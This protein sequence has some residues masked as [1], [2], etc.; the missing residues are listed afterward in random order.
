MRGR[1]IAIGIAAT[2]GVLAGAAPMA[3][4]PLHARV[5]GYDNVHVRVADP[6]K[7]VDW[8]VKHLGARSD[9]SN[10]RVHFGDTVVAIVATKSPQP[11]AGSV[12]DHFAVSFA[13]VD[14]RIRE[15]EAAGIAVKKSQSSGF[16]KSVFIEDPW[17]VRIELLQDP[18]ALGFHH[19]H[20]SVPDPQAVLAWYHERLGG[21]RGKLGGSDGLRYG[22][23]WL[24]AARAA[25]PTPSAERAIMN[26]AFRV[27]NLQQ[28]VSE[29]QTKG[30]QVVS[31][32]RQI[33]DLW[34]AFVEGPDGVRT[35]LLQ[36]PESR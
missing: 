32:P 26:V 3:A 2:L 22:N 19:V 6:A 35:E 21:E 20:L 30:V 5:T 27:A 10:A 17:G 24:L 8:Y 16:A 11:S 36:R 28:A 7:A 1:S 29:L 23:V 31:A 14:A 18:A 25:A 12:I 15:L 33:G 4:D 13:D 34:Y 9:G